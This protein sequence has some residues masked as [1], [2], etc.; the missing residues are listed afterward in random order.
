MASYIAFLRD[1]ARWLGAGFALSLLSTFGQTSFVAVFAG[2]VM[3]RTGLSDGG[4]GAVYMLGTTLSAIVMVWAGTL[5][6]RMPPR[7]L[8]TWVLAGLAASCAAMA[9]VSSIWLLPVLILGVRLFGQGMLSHVAY[10]AVARW[11]AA[12][13]GRALAITAFGFALG[14]ATIPLATVAALPLAGPT[15]LWIGAAAV[16]L[17]VILP[18]RALLARDRV[19]EGEAGAA[20]GAPGLGGR[21]W[22][23]REVIRTGL[24]WGLMPLLLGPPTFGT[25]LFF[26][27]VHLAEVKGWSHLAVVSLFPVIMVVSVVSTFLSGDLIDRLGATRLLPFSV[28][29]MAAGFLLFAPA[30]T[31]LMTVP[32]L[33]LIALTQGTM[34]TLPTAFWSELYG[35]R[36]IGAIKAVAGAVMVFGSAL[37]PGL[38]GLLI[39]AGISFP[40][41]MPWIALY[42]AASSALACWVLRRAVRRLAPA[43]A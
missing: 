40:R 36:H 2:A 5:A 15:A 33:M 3:E 23:R 14:Q 26:Q 4:W 19:P 22:T 35:T 8:A 10:T 20:G 7:R 12:S 11:F 37:G 9:L 13:R 16:C 41:Q 31:P 27:Q 18:L 32:A 34:G 29:P 42:L 21:H 24:F 38:T 30:P 1:N 43:I 39:D 17:L 28:L 6:D 25:A